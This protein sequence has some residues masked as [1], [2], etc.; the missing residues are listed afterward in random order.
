MSYWTKLIPKDWEA[1][2]LLE[3][4]S[5]VVD[6]RGKTCPVSEHGIPLIATNCIKE[7]GLYPV[8][9]KVRY[10]DNETYSNWFRAHPE[11]NDILFVNKWNNLSAHYFGQS[12][13]DS[14]Y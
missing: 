1:E 9:E 10:V 2:T 8:F 11:P 7:F 4:V 13:T 14:P 3:S 6:N 5:Q 12:Q